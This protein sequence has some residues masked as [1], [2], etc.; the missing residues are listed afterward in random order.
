MGRIAHRN[1]S[2]NKWNDYSKMLSYLLNNPCKQAL[3][4]M[5]AKYYLL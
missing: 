1:D 5:N 2:I 4:P 3:S